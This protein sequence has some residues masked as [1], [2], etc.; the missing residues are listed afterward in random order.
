MFVLVCLVLS[1]S[2]WGTWV[3][4]FCKRPQRELLV[5]CLVNK[6]VLGAAMCLALSL[7]TGDTV[8]TAGGPWSHGAHRVEGETV[9]KSNVINT[10]TSTSPEGSEGGD[11]ETACGRPVTQGCPESFTEEVLMVSEKEPSCWPLGD[12]H[13]GQREQH[14][15]RPCSRSLHNSWRSGRLDSS[16]EETD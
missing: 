15:Q 2:S 4:L 10:V 9:I 11:G 1:A 8:N 12:K 14:R 3:G 16:E 6:H 5:I 13:L 7:G